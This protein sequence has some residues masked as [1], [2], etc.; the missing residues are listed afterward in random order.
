MQSMVSDYFFCLI[1][2]G[3]VL[4]HP[5]FDLVSVVLTVVDFEGAGH[6]QRDQSGNGAAL[7]Q[8]QTH[9]HRSLR[10]LPHS[11]P[12][13]QVISII[14]SLFMNLFGLQL[15]RIECGHARCTSWSGLRFID[16]SS[17]IYF[18]S[19]R[20]T[21]LEFPRISLEKKSNSI[22]WVD[23]I[24]W[25]ESFTKKI[26]TVLQVVGGKLLGVGVEAI[27]VLVICYCGSFHSHFSVGAFIDSRLQYCILSY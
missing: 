21:F 22:S 19:I 1:W 26:W 8:H 20:R 11:C 15:S 9:R 18:N 5:R 10:Q 6:F 23:G 17:R 2:L 7:Q 14:S 27:V 13:R 4:E 3:I 25:F 12:R 24:L 16:L